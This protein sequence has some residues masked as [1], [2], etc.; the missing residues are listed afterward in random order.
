MEL[1]LGSEASACMD[2]SC[3]FHSTGINGWNHSDAE[4][5]QQEKCG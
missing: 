2:T 4:K 3:S 1:S 5:P